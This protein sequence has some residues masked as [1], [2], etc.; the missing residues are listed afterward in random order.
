LHL[1][2]ESKSV[3]DICEKQRQAAQLFGEEVATA[4]RHR[5]ADL[6][7]AQTIS[8]IQTGRP[9]LDTDGAELLIDLAPGYVLVCKPNHIVRPR[10]NAGVPD[11]TKVSR[12]KI[13]D[14]R[15]AEDET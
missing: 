5:L 9:R 3:R 6:S 15:R 1:A 13:V 4:L 10:E 7:A 2:F 8:D 11:W 12:V 14:I